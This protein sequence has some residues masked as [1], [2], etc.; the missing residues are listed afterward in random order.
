MAITRRDLSFLVPLLASRAGAQQSAQPTPL[1]V[2]PT[3][4]Y[5]NGDIPYRG[6]EK[7]KGREIFHGTT[8]KNFELQMHESVLG[9]G[10]QAHA[11]HKHEHEE[12]IVVFEGTLE[13]WMEG[14]TQLAP[15]GSVIY[16][17]SNQMHSSRNAGSGPCRYYVLELRG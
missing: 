16:F 15:A 12:I 2:L 10:Q 6:D 9:P 5:A 7:K 14:K 11:P 3:H 1:A 17:G 8:H 13:P 4:V